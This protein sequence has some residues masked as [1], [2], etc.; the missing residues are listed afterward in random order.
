VANRTQL[1]VRL[2]VI[3]AVVGLVVWFVRTIDLAELGHQFSEATWWPLAVAAVLNFGMLLG[4]AVCWRIALAPAHVVPTARLMRYTIA[5]FAASAIAPARAG[6]VLRVWV[7]KRRDGVPASATTATAVSEKL[8]DGVAMLM[9]VAPLPWLVPD[10]PA[11]VGNSIA[12][13]AFV[14]VAAF[15]FLYIAV[16]RV[17]ATAE[18][19]TVPAAKGARAWLRRFVAGMHVLRNPRRTLACLAALIVVWLLDLASVLLVLHAVGVA[20][21]VGAA[22]L[23]LF[24]INLA[25]MLPSTPAQLG[26]LELGAIGALHVLGVAK[27]PAAAFALLYHGVQVLPLIAVGLVLELPLVLGRDGE[28]G[29]ASRPGETT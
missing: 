29:A 1:V 16:G 8:L 11:W 26:A 10:L 21:S 7:L 18:E 3:A 27:E 25:V 17:T 22:L 13:C 28:D 5:A 6:E 2:A 9:L 14:A 12:A 20:A 19:A 15:V 4:K 24:A 23:V